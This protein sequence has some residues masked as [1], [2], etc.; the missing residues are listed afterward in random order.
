MPRCEMRRYPTHFGARVACSSP[1]S[2]AST[3]TS[4]AVTSPG[5][6]RRSTNGMPGSLGVP[7]DSI[8]RPNNWRKRCIGSSG[9]GRSETTA[10]AA[11]AATS[12]PSVQF[13]RWLALIA[14]G[15]ERASCALRMNKTP[16]TPI[17]TRAISAL[18]S[19]GNLRLEGGAGLGLTG[20]SVRRHRDHVVDRERFDRAFHQ[21]PPGRRGPSAVVAGEASRT[22]REQGRSSRTRPPT[23]G[24]TEGQP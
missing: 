10:P 9:G 3:S 7:I 1:A 22:R 18:S 21:W 20:C 6:S 4:W 13:L 8:C 12:M 24:R 16:T 17:A 11:S 14:Y 2:R 23:R 15:S 5:I 19:G